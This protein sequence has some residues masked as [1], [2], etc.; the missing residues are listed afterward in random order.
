MIIRKLIDRLK[1]YRVYNAETGEMIREVDTM[2]QAENL[3]SSLKQ[4]SKGSYK[5][6]EMTSRKYEIL[7]NLYYA[8]AMILVAALLC[9]LFVSIIT[10][11][12]P[13]FTT[14]DD[15]TDCVM[16]LNSDW[17]RGVYYYFPSETITFVFEETDGY[18]E[19]KAPKDEWF[20]IQK[21]EDVDAYF[22]SQF[23]G[24]RKVE[25]KEGSIPDSFFKSRMKER[26]KYCA[27]AD[28]SRSDCFSEVYYDTLDELLFVRFRD[29]GALYVY[30]DYPPGEWDYFVEAD[31]LGSFYNQYVKGQWRSEKIE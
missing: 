2:T 20:S 16:D 24:K 3:V 7:D 19:Y 30:Y 26:K 17:F 1:K 22:L 18:I 27:F 15:P 23:Y 31:S 12:K 25:S 11:S 10:P 6:E 28:A 21:E 4:D 14:D 8:C 5:I 9:L 29:S 13:K